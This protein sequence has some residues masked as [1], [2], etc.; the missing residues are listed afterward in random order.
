MRSGQANR[1][2]PRCEPNFSNKKC[3]EFQRECANFQLGEKCE[4]NEKVAV[5]LARCFAHFGMEGMIA[6]HSNAAGK[7]FSQCGLKTAI[8]KFGKLAE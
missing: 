7:V 3:D 5:T 4:H 2:V 8:K 6:K 1:P